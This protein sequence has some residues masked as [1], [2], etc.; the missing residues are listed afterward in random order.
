MRP[1]IVAYK[2]KRHCPPVDL[3]KVGAHE[4]ADFWDAIEGPRSGG[5]VLDP[6]DFYLLAS[7]GTILHPLWL[8]GGDGAV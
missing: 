1:S 2:A 5:L 3:S 4:A 7:Q 6:G 8:G